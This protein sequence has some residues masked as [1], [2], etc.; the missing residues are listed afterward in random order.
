MR[1]A[2]AD[3]AILRSNSAE[4][5]VSEIVLSQRGELTKTMRWLIFEQSRKVLLDVLA[6]ELACHMLIT[7][8][9]SERVR[10][11]WLAL[12][13]HHIASI[14]Q[15]AQFPQ[16]QVCLLLVELDN[17]LLDTELNE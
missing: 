14:D 10:H 13:E 16:I 12:C 4:R 11:T 8:Q 5:D 15:R 1:A 9:F 7:H 2:V 17:T 6:R 3:M